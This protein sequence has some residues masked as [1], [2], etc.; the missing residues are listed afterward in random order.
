MFMMNSF[1][2]NVWPCAVISY[3]YEKAFGVCRTNVTA[4]TA[5]LTC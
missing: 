1:G 3:S 2:M 5:V 4:R